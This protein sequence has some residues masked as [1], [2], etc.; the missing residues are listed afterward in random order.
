MQTFNPTANNSLQNLTLQ[1]CNTY[2]N[3]AKKPVFVCLGTTKVLGDCLGPIVGELLTKKYSICNYVYGNLAQNITQKNIS[4]YFCFIKA[5]HPK[6]PIYVIDACLGDLTAVG[7]VNFKSGAIYTNGTLTNKRELTDND[8]AT[9]VYHY[10]D[11]NLTAC[12]NTVGIN[13][14]LFLKTI[15]LNSVLECAEFIAKAI[16]YS[17][18]LFENL[19]QP[20]TKLVKN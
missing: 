5:K 19:T 18:K 12:V 17:T 16:Y 9:S 6:T 4:D 8:N 13:S 10:G 20:L 1:L 15:K 14:L 2:F 11:Y 3:H 7:Y